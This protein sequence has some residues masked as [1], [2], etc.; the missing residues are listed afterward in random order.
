MSARAEAVVVLVDVHELVTREACSEP[1]EAH[2]AKTDRAGFRVVGT[3][4]KGSVGARRARVEAAVC[5]R[6]SN[7]HR[8]TDS[9]GVTAP[10]ESLLCSRVRRADESVSSYECSTSAC[11]YLALS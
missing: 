8:L 7:L 9:V 4:V 2:D 11:G 5:H 10:A 1:D 6:W 3:L